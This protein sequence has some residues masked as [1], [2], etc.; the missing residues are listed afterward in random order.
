MTTETKLL[1][2]KAYPQLPSV[3]QILGTR[4]LLINKGK[5]GQIPTTPYK[6]GGRSLPAYSPPYILIYLYIYY[7]LSFI[8]GIEGKESI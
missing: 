6:R 4:K 5:G 2:I 3:P 1:I 7:N 8:K